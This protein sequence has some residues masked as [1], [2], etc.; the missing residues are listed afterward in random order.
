[1]FLQMGIDSSVLVTFVQL[2]AD[3]KAAKLFNEFR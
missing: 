3:Y 2:R 1:M